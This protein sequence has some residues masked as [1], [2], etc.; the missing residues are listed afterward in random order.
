MDLRLGLFFIILLPSTMMYAASEPL[1]SE[2][3][4]Y[5]RS[6]REVKNLYSAI[7]EDRHIGAWN[8]YSDFF[9]SKKIEVAAIQNIFFNLDRQSFIWT[10]SDRSALIQKKQENLI[11]SIYVNDCSWYETVHKDYTLRLGQLKRWYK[12][13]VLSGRFDSTIRNL[14]KSFSKPHENIVSKTKDNLKNNVLHQIFYEYLNLK[15]I[16]L[17]KFP[18][19]SYTEEDYLEG[20]KNLVYHYL[21]DKDERTFLYDSYLSSLVAALDKHSAYKYPSSPTQN[22]A[23]SLGL[24]TEFVGKGRL[25]VVGFYENSPAKGLLQEG[26]IVLSIDGHVLDKDTPIRETL[27]LLYGKESVTVDL[28]ILRASGGEDIVL[29]R[30]LKLRTVRY[31]QLVKGHVIKS[32]NGVNIGYISIPWFYGAEGVLPSASQ[33]FVDIAQ[34]I[35]KNSDAVVIDLRG[36]GGGF[37]SEARSIA[38]SLLLS[39]KGEGYYNDLSE[40]LERNQG[41]KKIEVKATI[42]DCMSLKTSKGKQRVEFMGLLV[43]LDVNLRGISGGQHE[44]IFGGY[45]ACQY[46][47][48][49]NK[50]PVVILIDEMTASA[51]EFVA[52]ALQDYRRTVVLG[53]SSSWGKGTWQNTV[54]RDTKDGGREYIDSV[55]ITKGLWFLPSGRSVQRTGLQPDILVRKHSKEEPSV[56]SLWGRRLPVLALES[57]YT[58]RHPL[59]TISASKQEQHKTFLEVLNLK[60]S[61]RQVSDSTSVE[62]LHDVVLQEALHV[63]SDWLEYQKN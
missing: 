58:N 42:R 40:L 51:S 30:V 43:P 1:T 19:P 13:K 54:H 14:E 50:K 33:D 34:R 4:G 21:F 45:V 52:G 31:H 39:P 29:D 61:N 55:L 63:V 9:E 47:A 25:I 27:L 53:S 26:D 37:L 38:G 56:E 2:A 20:A 17:E 49:F 16:F 7:F 62:A 57:P 44:S 59:Y 22:G 18:H 41:T 8:A 11:D 32:S 10:Q 15:E 23:A 60:S 6:C 12:Q 35:E 24:K 3:S 48:L 5:L 36:N 28:K 46:H